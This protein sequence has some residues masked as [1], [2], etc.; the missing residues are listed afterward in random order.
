ME[1]AWEKTS[2]ILVFN[3]IVKGEGLSLA[4]L[5]AQRKVVSHPLNEYL[6]VAFYK[7]FLYKKEGFNQE[8]RR[9]LA[10]K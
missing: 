4:F 9:E 10:C 2:N 6:L 3:K 7:I 5:F 1:I 8:H